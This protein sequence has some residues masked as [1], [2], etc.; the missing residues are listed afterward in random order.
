MTEEHGPEAVRLERLW[1]GEFGD[2][3]VERN[4]ALDVRRADFWHGILEGLAVRSVLEIGCGQGA[5]LGPIAALPGNPVVWGVDVNEAALGR[6][7][8]NVPGVNAI[9]A[10]ARELPFRDRWFDLVFTM[11]VLIHQPEETLPL[12]MAEIVRCSGRFVLWGEYHADE[13]TETPYRGQRGALVKRDYGRL[14][15]EL[16]PELRLRAEGFLAPEDGFDR[17]TWQL[18]EKAG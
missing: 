2:A 13:R 18:L 12:V 1:A 16:F 14:Y 6:V 5:N 9:R 8:A 11:G 10:V 15:R 17:V 4:S 3:Y 7:R